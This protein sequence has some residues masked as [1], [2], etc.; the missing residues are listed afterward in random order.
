MNDTVAVAVGAAP[1]VLCAL[2]TIEFPE[3]EDVA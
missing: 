2:V 1:V 3:S